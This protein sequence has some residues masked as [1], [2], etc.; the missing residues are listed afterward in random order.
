MRVEPQSGGRRAA[1][2]GCSFAGHCLLLPC[3]CA[4]PPDMKPDAPSR[5]AVTTGE[6]IRAANA[7]RIWAHLRPRVSSVMSLQWSRCLGAPSDIRQQQRGHRR[8]GPNRS[9]EFCRLGGR[10]ADRRVN[11]AHNALLMGHRGTDCGEPTGVGGQ[12]TA[13]GRSPTAV[14]RPRAL[15]R[16]SGRTVSRHVLGLGGPGRNGFP[17]DLSAFGMAQCRGPGVSGAT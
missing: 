9:S 16:R 14:A 3:F 4:G 17:G 6:C 10:S 11:H 7:W 15:L 2:C 12:S 13:I 8:I 5:P 1:Q